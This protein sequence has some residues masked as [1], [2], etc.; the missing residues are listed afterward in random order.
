MRTRNRSITTKKTTTTMT[1]NRSQK[2]VGRLSPTPPECHPLT[3][4]RSRCRPSRCLG[5]GPGQGHGAP[6]FGRHH[7]HHA[8]REE[9]PQAHVRSRGIGIQGERNI[10]AVRSHLSYSPFHFACFIQQQRGHIRRPM[11]VAPHIVL[12]HAAPL[13]A[14]PFRRP[15]PPP[16]RTSTRPGLPIPP[17]TPLVSGSSRSGPPSQDLS[18]SRH[19]QGLCDSPTRSRPSTRFCSFSCPPDRRRRHVARPRLVAPHH[20]SSHES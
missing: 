8:P 10:P 9:A 4:R 13:T 14:H 16:G 18:R 17:S 6:N 19:E 5:Q 3:S 11:L 7:Y 2:K 20:K 12:R 15:P 1:T